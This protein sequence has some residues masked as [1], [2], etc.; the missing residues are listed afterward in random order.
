[1]GGMPSRG[2]P[3]EKISS[4]LTSDSSK[5]VFQPMLRQAVAEIWSRSLRVTSR[6]PARRR[7]RPAPRSGCR[8]RWPVPAAGCRCRPAPAAREPPRRAAWSQPGGPDAGDGEATGDGEA[9]AVDSAELSDAA[10]GDGEAA[11]SDVDAG[12][13]VLAAGS[14]CSKCSAAQRGRKQ[15]ATRQVE[16]RIHAKSVAGANGLTV[17]LSSRFIGKY[18]NTAGA[19]V[20]LKWIQSPWADALWKMST[21]APRPPSASRRMMAGLAKAVRPG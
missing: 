1:M 8:T 4:N 6:R 10:A 16:R 3:P 7:C 13:R 12:A 2:T 11:A 17:R 20:G 14:Q 15:S 5:L 19:S 18:S 9:S 21:P